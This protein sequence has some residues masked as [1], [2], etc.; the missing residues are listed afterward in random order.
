M[1]GV[2]LRRILG[3]TGE[4][5]HGPTQRILIVAFAVVLLLLGGTAAFLYMRGR[6]PPPSITLNEAD[7]NEA[8]PY[9][10]EMACIDQVL[11]RHDLEA[12]QVEPALASCRASGS[13]TNRMAGQ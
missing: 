1:E 4:H 6:P 3:E 13:E 11:Q 7:E 10:V 12:N 8:N 5:M 9:R 2:D